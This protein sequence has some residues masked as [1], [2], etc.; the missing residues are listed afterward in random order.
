M[1]SESEQKLRSERLG[2]RVTE[3]SSL[4][5]H[6]VSLTYAL[7]KDGRLPFVRVGRHRVIPAAAVH[8]LLEQQS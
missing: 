4:L 1:H 2:Y 3:V 6:S 5:G 8:K 7:M